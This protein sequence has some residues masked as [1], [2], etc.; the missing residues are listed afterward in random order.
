[1]LL[2]TYDATILIEG[3]RKKVMHKGCGRY[4]SDFYVESTVQYSAVEI[5]LNC[6]QTDLCN[7]STSSSVGLG[8]NP[9]KSFLILVILLEIIKFV[10]N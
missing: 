2:K 10:I 7:N 6:C 5:K 9:S 3:E 4:C 1:M 8:I